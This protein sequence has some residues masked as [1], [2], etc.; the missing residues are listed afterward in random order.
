[1]P[2]MA[3]YYNLVEYQVYGY[4]ACQAN[5]VEVFDTARCPVLSDFRK[6]MGDIYRCGW[7]VMYLGEFHSHDSTDELLYDKNVAQKLMS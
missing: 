4:L 7:L 2:G 3:K 5:L 1:M 6:V